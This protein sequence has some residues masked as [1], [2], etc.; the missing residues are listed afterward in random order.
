MNRIHPAAARR[1]FTLTEVLI[2]F[3]VLLIGVVSVIAV[4]PVGVR[5][6]Q[7]AVLDTRTSLVGM[8]GAAEFLAMGWAD[9][10]Y[11]LAPPHQGVPTANGQ[12][13]FPPGPIVPLSMDP[14]DGPPTTSPSGGDPRG[15]DSATT[16]AFT[17]TRPAFGSGA[18]PYASN[19]AY[20]AIMPA[21]GHSPDRAVFTAGTPA[22]FTVPGQRMHPL[23]AGSA[24]FP[25]FI[26]PVLANAP[27][28]QFD[29]SAAVSAISPMY[30]RIAI[31]ATLNPNFAT[32]APFAGNLNDL[33]IQTISEAQF[34]PAGAGGVLVSPS[35]R[36]QYLK[37]RFGS[38]DQTH[39]EWNAPVIPYNPNRAGATAIPGWR[40]LVSAD[41]GT[42]AAPAVAN[43]LLPPAY[44]AGAATPEFNTAN[45]SSEYSFAFVVK[46]R[47]LG[48]NPSAAPMPT[49]GAAGP[50]SFLTP[51]YGATTQEDVQALVFHKRP[52]AR[53]YQL[54]RGCFFAGST[55]A[56][57]CW[58][59]TLA[60]PPEI[61]RGQWLMEAT[62]SPGKKDDTPQT[63][64]IA[65]ATV[66]FPDVPLAPVALLGAAPLPAT[67]FVKYRHALEFHRVASTESPVLVTTGGNSYMY[68]VVNL[69]EPVSGYPIRH[70]LGDARSVPDI[71]DGGAGLPNTNWTFDGT[72]AIPNVIAD[73]ATTVWTPVVLLDGL[74]E[75]F[76]VRK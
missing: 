11:L 9:D 41:S 18:A 6:V 28:F 12:P 67:G 45:R 25:I 23:A 33:V 10:P 48:A 22:T 34:Q 56:T 65:G 62:L 55:V 15:V 63:Q 1:G 68:Q 64:T 17:G 4:F 53:G 37:Q 39:F 59:P 40:F 13:A 52:T 74:R 16:P 8:E 36:D 32:M 3:F 69:E 71:Y 60:Q 38:L 70:V 26:D 7:N 66:N 73:D 42:A 54:V 2:A 19:N 75:V 47:R 24:G 46:N 72:H 27:D 50:F 5:E 49:T 61:R 20:A 57:L 21:N 35:P 58:D 30:K 44:K 76:T 51:A 43:P 31:A 14:T 29:G